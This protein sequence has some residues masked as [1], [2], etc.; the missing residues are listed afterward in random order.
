MSAPESSILDDRQRSSPA[1]RGYVPGARDTAA[2]AR[3]RWWS[4]PFVR[5]LATNMAVGFSIS[6]FYLLPKHLTV[7]YA[8]TPGQVGAAVG[9]FGLMCVLVVPWLGRLVNALGLP[10]TL[11][12]SQMVMAACGFAFA[13]V[14]G[15]GGM[16]LVL[17]AV[18]GLATA[19]VM[20]A[21]VAMVCELAPADK[22]G[23]AMG[24]AGAA[25]LVMNAIAPA[26]AEPIGTRYGFA[27]VFILSGAAALG[28]AWLA[29]RL[30]EAAAVPLRLAP[31]PLPRRTFRVLAALAVTGAGFHVVMA[32]LAPLAL[33]RGINTVS[34]FFLAYTAAALAMRT[35]GSGLTDRLGPKRTAT[36]G[37]LLYGAFIAAV[38]AVGSCSLAGLGL[39][40]GLAHGA[41]F[42]ALMAML[43]DQVPPAERARLAAFANGVLNLGMLTVLGF[44]QLANRAGLAMVFLITGGLV[45][46]F[47][48]L[49]SPRSVERPVALV[50]RPEG[51]A[52]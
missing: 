41:L 29:R 43:F 4:G 27:W 45:A 49:L 31:K 15:I 25:S 32:F 10:R 13:W 8:A 40:F 20:T 24:L 26:V 6:C 14:D 9:I 11:F 18:Q 16:L 1:T 39:G 52:R 19:A 3:L 44:G 23:R 46:T 38:A 34:S 36:A 5:L 30:P 50:P 37:I 33:K 7:S 28:G 12:L 35:L 17:R 51:P 21:G 47:A 22:L 2:P 42:P 48:L